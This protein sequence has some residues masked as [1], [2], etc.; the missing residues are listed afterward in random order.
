MSRNNIYEQFARI[1]KAISSPKRLELLDILAQGERTVEVLAKETNMTMGNTSQHLQVLKESNFIE[2]EKRG[3]YVFYKLSDESVSNFINSVYNL[4]ENQLSE[5][6]KIKNKFNNSNNYEEI[7]AEE[8]FKRISE[9][10]ILLIDVRPK[11]EYENAHIKGAISIPLSEIENKIK[12]IPNNKDIVAYCRGKHCIL[13]IKALE[14]LNKNGFK[15]FRLQDSIN[16]WAKK[17][18]PV[19]FSNL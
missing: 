3:M 9:N 10:S 12:N 17:N 13:S 4:A 19:V 8:L 18:F 11:E 16:D 1:G 7:K 2:S 14:I 15:S 5:I 6:E